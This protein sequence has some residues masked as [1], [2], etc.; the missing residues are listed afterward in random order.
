EERDFT[1]D[2]SAFHHQ[3]R[4]LSFLDDAFT[5]Q[6]VW[7][8][9]KNMP[10]D[11]APGTDG[12]TGRFYRCCWDIISSDVLLALAAIHR[13]DVVLFVR[14][15]RDDLLMIMDILDCFGH[16]SGLRANLNK[17]SA[18]S[19]Q[20]TEDGNNLILG[21]LSCKDSKFP[22]TY[23]GLPLTL[24]KP[25]KSDLLSLIDKVADK[26][27][28]W[29]AQL[30][31]EAGRLAIVKSV[32]SAVPIYLMIA[33]DLPKWVIKSIDKKRRSFLCKGH[34]QAHGGNCLVSWTR[35]QRPLMYGGLG[36]HDLQRLGWALRIWWLWLLKTDDS[37]PWAGLPIQV[38]RN[39]R[40]LFDMAVVTTV[41]NG[42]STN[43]W[44]DRWLQGKPVAELAPYL[45]NAIPK[46][47]VKRRIV[48][49][50]LIN[51]SWVTD[52]KGALTVQVLREYLLIWDLVD[53][54]TLQDGVQDQHQW[55]FSSSGTYSSRSAYLAMFMG[56]I[57]FSPWKRIWKSW[58]PPN[59]MF[60]IWLAILNRCWTSD[61]LA[62]RGLPH[63]SACI[64]CDQE[65]ETINHILTSCVLSREVW[66]RVLSSLNFAWV[67]PPT[68]ASRFNSLWI[69]ATRS[70]P[71]QLQN[72]FNSLV[73]LVS[74]ELWKHR[75]ACIF[76]GRRSDLQA[77]LCSV[78]A[79][80]SLC[81][82]E[83]CD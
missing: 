17:S 46:K 19:I 37:R 35:V 2:L 24:H 58:A 18:V 5:L 66:T 54:V 78:T 80:G 73:F 10:L 39:A 82:T 79:K 56:T 48:S 62:K 20:C 42:E 6:E 27:P 50:A 12:F 14:P 9:I 47:I 72:G 32:L 25:S 22:T 55:K 60:F 44:T 51:R 63:Q 7:S 49:Q 26:L 77:V 16:A 67:A 28:G 8:T 81:R 71:K 41:G 70:I 30:L 53:E 13:D 65:E 76:E 59:S 40:A 31:N 33:M 34:G 3:Q 61:R 4:D 57:N 15:S 23:L 11:K 75:N 45:L 1:L 36:I 43:F 52:I 68:S 69:E 29:K 64:F 21:T 83:T 38:P 74:W